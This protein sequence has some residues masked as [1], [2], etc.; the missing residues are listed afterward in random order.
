MTLGSV[1]QSAHAFR[2]GRQI[3]DGATVGVDEKGKGVHWAFSV[4]IKDEVVKDGHCLC[5]QLQLHDMLRVGLDPWQAIKG[6][7][8]Q[9]RRFR[10]T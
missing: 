2:G 3:D 6:D 1:S 9:C 5:C 10:L 7:Q 8:G 4:D